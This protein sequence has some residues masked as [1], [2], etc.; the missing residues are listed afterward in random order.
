MSSKTYTEI[1]N[2]YEALAHTVEYMCERR[3]S[4]AKLYNNG[5]FKQVV[6]IGSGSSY[7]ISEA[8]AMSANLR[9]GLPSAALT[10]GD[11]MLHPEQYAPLFAGRTL[12]I[13]L[14]RSGETSELV[15]AALCLRSEFKNTVVLAITCAERSGVANMADF[16]LE[17]PWAFDES[18]CQTRSVTNLY[19]AALIF[20]GIAS[21]CGEII[22]G[23]R[24]LAEQGNQFLEKVEGV[25][26]SVS[27]LNWKNAVLLSD[28]EGFGITGEAALAFNEISLTPAVYKHLLD[29][30]HGPIVLVDDSTLV[31]ARLDQEQ[32]SYQRDL[33]CDL[34]KRGAHVIVVSD[35]EVPR[36]DG[37][38][39][40]LT[41]GCSLNQGVVNAIML[42]VAQLFSYY[43]ALKLNKD[44]DKPE[45]L[46]AWIKL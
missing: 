7:H 36:I 16:A 13:F 33:V 34:V 32:F 6:V 30:R 4:C 40:T 44:P 38:Y 31:I 10:G 43:R 27:S 11:L 26:E 28:G 2:Q 46:E 37:V 21:G 5:C 45:G 1:H 17:I 35:A 25:A 8:V 24:K 14:T 3:D 15:N 19:A 22:E 20:I 12:A 41:F 42:P 9:L 23:Y 29:I 39:A 18:V